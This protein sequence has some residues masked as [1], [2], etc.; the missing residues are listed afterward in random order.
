MKIKV[1]DKC[2]QKNILKKCKWIFKVPAGSVGGHYNLDVCEDCEPGF[3]T[4][5]ATEKLLACGI[6]LPETSE[7]VPDVQVLRWSVT[8]WIHPK[9][10]GD[11]KQVRMFFTD[12]PTAE[13]IQK[14]LKGYGSA[15][16]TDYSEPEKQTV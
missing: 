8:G 15:V 6:K 12:K 16:L 5:S 1:C 13:E 4:M 3:K 9:N 2:L 7:V 11:D 10:G 14:K